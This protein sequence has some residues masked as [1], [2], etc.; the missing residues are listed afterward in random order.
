MLEGLLTA[1][2]ISLISSLMLLMA[3]GDVAVASV[4]ERGAPVTLEAVA[5]ERARLGLDLPFLQRYLNFL[6]RAVQ[7]DFGVSV[8][9]GRSVASDIGERLGPTL[10]LAAAGAAVAVVLALAI[11]LGEVLVPHRLATAASRALT[12]VLVSV[13]GFALAFLLVSVVS[14]R[15]GWLP[16]QGAGSVR[17]LVLPAL[18]L[19]LPAGAA[20]GRV[21]S[22]R[23]REVMAEPYLVTAR[24]QGFGQVAALVRFALPNAGVT[25]L[26]VAGNILAALASGTLVV[27]ELFG[28]PG[29]G[30]YLIDSL[31]YR[32]GFALQASILVLSVLMIAIRMATL[33]MATLLDPRSGSNL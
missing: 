26:V 3:R 18:V 6:A 22:T 7:G 33:L 19:G 24:A 32:D 20:L 27:E 1:I 8:R 2:A 30:S 13:P 9:T 21:L 12:L 11:G 16:T 5:S 25:S 29:L 10:T 15:L 14:L 4:Q 28:W 23:L 17:T 31:R